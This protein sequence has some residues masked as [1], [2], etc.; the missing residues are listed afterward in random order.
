MIYDQICVYPRSRSLSFVLGPGGPD[1]EQTWDLTLDL[2][3]SLTIG[4]T[5][6]KKNQKLGE[7]FKI[8][9]SS[10]SWKAYKPQIREDPEITV[11]TTIHI[12]FHCSKLVSKVR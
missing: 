7:L 9:S 6:T 2:D 4:K 10:G 1:L 11:V 12:T 8:L 3:L 5:I